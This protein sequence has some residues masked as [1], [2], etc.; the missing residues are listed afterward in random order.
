MSGEALGARVAA[1]RGDQGARGAARAR[2][3]D[4]GTRVAVR[5]LTLLLKLLEL[6]L[7]LERN[8]L[9]L[10]LL[11][12]RRGG[13]R[14]GDCALGASSGRRAGGGGE[15]LELHDAIW[16]RT[17]AERG[18]LSG[19]RYCTAKSPV[20]DL[21]IS[22]PAAPGRAQLIRIPSLVTLRHAR[23]T[24]RR[25]FFQAG[26]RQEIG[27]RQLLAARTD[28]AGARECASERSGWKR[29]ERR[30]AALDAAEGRGRGRRLAPTLRRAPTE[31][32]A[33]AS[34]SRRPG[35]AR[36]ARARAAVAQ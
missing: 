16:P 5:G 22:L 35:C 11:R 15:G 13:H 18:A 2:R 36:G 7:L 32:R 31:V 19:R 14:A 8:L 17:C 30:S 24:A 21:R 6:V 20:S 25:P 12:R 10:G 33:R 1:R 4:Q 23:N 29:S 26:R 27:R 9:G 28:G 3:G 34:R